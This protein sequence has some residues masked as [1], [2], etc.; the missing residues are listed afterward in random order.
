LREVYESV[1]V[2]RV[3]VV[4]EGEGRAGQAGRSF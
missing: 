4:R 1:A 2:D 3:K